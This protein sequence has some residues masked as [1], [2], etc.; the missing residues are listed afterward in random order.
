M[1]KFLSE[2][3]ECSLTFKIEI[4]IFK[5]STPDLEVL[6][7]AFSKINANNAIVLSGHSIFEVDSFALFRKHMLNNSMM[8]VVTSP[9]RKNEQRTEHIN[10]KGEN[11]TIVVSEN[12]SSMFISNISLSIS[13]NLFIPMDLLFAVPR[14][15]LR[16]D[17]VEKKAYILSRNLKKITGIKYQHENTIKQLVPRAINELTV[18][19]TNSRPSMTHKIAKLT[20]IDLNF[21]FIEEFFAKICIND[22]LQLDQNQTIVEGT[23]TIKSLIPSCQDYHDKNRRVLNEITTARSLCKLN[24]YFMCHCNSKK[25]SKN[26]INP[27]TKINMFKS[28]LVGYKTDIRTNCYIGEGS[29]IGCHGSI[30]NSIIGTDCR[31]GDNVKIVECLVLDRVFIENDTSLLKTLIGEGSIIVGKCDLSCRVTKANSFLNLKIN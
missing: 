12:F 7:H 13:N 16:T 21:T 27:K 22:Y 2:A 19:Y 14:F 30:N 18:F 17:L 15:I 4:M 24:Q 25:H 29:V 6:C 5:K 31:I 8:T 10:T 20:N 11:F 28:N 9:L 26:Q 3:F 23:N 1:T